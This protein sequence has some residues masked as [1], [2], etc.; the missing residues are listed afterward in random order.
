MKSTASKTMWR[1]HQEYL[2]TKYWKERVFWTGS[3][4]VASCGGVTVDQLKAY[5]EQQNSPTE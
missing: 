1:N 2:E 3:Y 4:F 5:V